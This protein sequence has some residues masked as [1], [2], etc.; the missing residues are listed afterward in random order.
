MN[1]TKRVS[2]SCK[3]IL[4]T[5]KDHEN[6]NLLS[7]HNHIGDNIAVEVEKYRFQ[8][9]RQAETTNDKPNQILIF[10]TAAASDEVKARPRINQK[11]STSN[12]SSTQA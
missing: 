8:M 2:D 3:A 11:T 6:A 9:K 7:Q 5:T 10:I 12:Q 1:C 4:K